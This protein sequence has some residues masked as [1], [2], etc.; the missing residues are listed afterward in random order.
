MHAG[1]N[2]VLLLFKKGASLAASTPHDGV[3]EL[4]LAFTIAAA[5]LTNWE[6]WLQERRIAVELKRTWYR[7]A[8]ASTFETL[9]A[10]CSN[11][12]LQELGPFI[13]RERKAGPRRPLLPTLPESA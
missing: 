12:P 7:S 5:E 2:Q 6:S 8:G 4:H 3:G 13:D 9:T 10:I 1:P 11:S